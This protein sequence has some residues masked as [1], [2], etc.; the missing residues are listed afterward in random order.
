MDA[1]LIKRTIDLAK[2][3]ILKSEQP[4]LLM[5]PGDNK[6]HRWEITVLLNGQPANLSGMTASGVFMRH[7]GTV[8]TCSG[9]NAVISEN[10]V[11]VTFRPECYNVP[12]GMRGAVRISGSAGTVTLGDQAFF[13][14]PAFDGQTVTDEY[15]PTLAQLLDNVSRLEQANAIGMVLTSI[16]GLMTAVVQDHKLVINKVA[17]T[18][19]GAYAAAV[20]AGY[21]GTET[22]WNAFVAAVT[23]N[24]SLITQANT[25]AS[26]A[27][28]TANG[29]AAVTSATVTADKDDWTGSAVPYTQTISCSIATATNNL[30]VGVG[31]SLTNEQKAALDAANIVCTGQGAGTITLT[32]YGVKPTVDLPI[33][34]LGVN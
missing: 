24:T 12:G 32:C 16:S 30:I 19:S 18:D 26:T 21:T 2:P 20:A 9:A 11:T 13:V 8:V 6:A 10:V 7:D 23:N 1:W 17:I 28:A 4:Y 25:N 29:K 33:N 34:V 3:P 22:E 31:G 15:I 5:V 27:L 14:Q